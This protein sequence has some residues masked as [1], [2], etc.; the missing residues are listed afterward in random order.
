MQRFEVAS[1]SWTA[2]FVQCISLLI[3]VGAQPSLP[4]ATEVTPAE[5]DGLP[6]WI[7]EQ[8][9]ALQKVAVYILVDRS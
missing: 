2:R 8:Y 7:D 9:S 5:S 4:A 1:R 6:S 3:V